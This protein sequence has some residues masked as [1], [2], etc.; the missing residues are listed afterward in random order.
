MARRGRKNERTAVEND[1]THPRDSGNE[2]RGG[3]TE[4]KLVDFAED[5]GRL[6]GTAQQKATAWLGQR[7]EI[8]NQLTQI[9][10]TANS[11]LQELSGAGAKLAA[12]VQRGRRGRPPGAKNK[13]GRRRPQASASSAAGK[14]GRKRRKMSPEARAKIAA[15][16]RARWAKKRAA[17]K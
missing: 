5:L 4:D 14:T 10:D 1:R 7:Q 2:G 3:R 15:A 16:Q 12:A 6:L 8:A 17:D 9:R 11:Y 13:A